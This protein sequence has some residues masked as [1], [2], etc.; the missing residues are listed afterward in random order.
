MS[1]LIYYTRS[2][3]CNR[4]DNSFKTSAGKNKYD[5]GATYNTT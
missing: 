1:K 3:M 4:K 2:S 5:K